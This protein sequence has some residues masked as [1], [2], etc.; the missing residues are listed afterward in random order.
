MIS[1]R[2]ESESEH[3]F[4]KEDENTE[5]ETEDNFKDSTTN[6]GFVGRM[7]ML[8]IMEYTFN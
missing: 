5:T 2:T 4:T 3:S 1:Q 7:I 6:F 8:W